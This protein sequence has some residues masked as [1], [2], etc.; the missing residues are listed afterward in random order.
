MIKSQVEKLNNLHVDI[1]KKTK[2]NV[3]KL[4]VYKKMQS[5]KQPNKPIIYLKNI[6]FTNV[7]LKMLLF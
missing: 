1:K 3:S 4:H 6:D 2:E 7:T 5:L